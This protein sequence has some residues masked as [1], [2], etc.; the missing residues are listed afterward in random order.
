MQSLGRGYV[1]AFNRRH[2]RRGALWDGRFRC[3]VLQVQTALLDAT[4]LIENLPV[5]HDLVGRAQDWPW[6]SARHHLGHSR[7]PLI[8]EHSVYWAIGNTPFERESAHAN[9]LRDGLTSARHDALLLALKRGHAVG[10]ATFIA[11]MA[12]ESGRPVGPR[13]RGR[14]KRT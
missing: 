3:S 6:S 4:V 8:T 5:E 1:S 2:A 13:Q 14:P 10:D 12:E 9:L 7:D 11:A